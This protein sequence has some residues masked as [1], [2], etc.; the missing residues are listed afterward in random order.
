MF[1]S[2]RREPSKRRYRLMMERPASR[3]CD[4]NEK[5]ERLRLFNTPAT[6]ADHFF[7]WRITLPAS[8]HLIIAR[9]RELLSL[10][11]VAVRRAHFH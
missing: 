5:T 8:L 9:L 4:S 3:V 10:V 11:F 6:T 7:S 1:Q 2:G